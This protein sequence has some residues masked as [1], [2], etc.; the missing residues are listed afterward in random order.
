M[1]WGILISRKWGLSEFLHFTGGPEPTGKG[2]RSKST[3]QENTRFKPD[4][5]CQC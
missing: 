3:N 5:Q 4:T 2:E 1:H